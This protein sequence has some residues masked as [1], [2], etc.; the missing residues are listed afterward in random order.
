MPFYPVLGQIS[1]VHALS[2]FFFK[3]HFNII[4]PSTLRA[5]KF[6]LYVRFPTELLYSFP[7]PVLGG[8]LIVH[9]VALHIPSE[10]CW[11]MTKIKNLLNVKFSPIS[12]YFLSLSFTNLPQHSVLKTC[13]IYPL[14]NVKYQVL[15]ANKIRG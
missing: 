8:T 9:L 2:F 4:S 12:C 14:F 1:F 13:G 11:M 10:Y 6:S 3:I 5:F 7:F 15:Y